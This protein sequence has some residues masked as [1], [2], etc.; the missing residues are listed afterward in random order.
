[1]TAFSSS[2]IFAGVKLEVHLTVTNHQL[3]LL[4]ENK[5][6]KRL[7]EAFREPLDVR[8]EVCDT[9][10]DRDYTYGR[11]EIVSVILYFTPPSPSKGAA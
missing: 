10:R 3:T 8:F 7:L 2:D 4:P 9:D 11:A 5:A 1:M 6:E